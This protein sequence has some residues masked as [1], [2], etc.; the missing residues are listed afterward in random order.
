MYFNFIRRELAVLPLALCFLVA[1]PRI[2][3]QAVTGTIVG[4]VTDATGAVVPNATVVVSLT[5]QN[6]STTM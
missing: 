2:L 4:T 6:V 1:A 5:G 3:A